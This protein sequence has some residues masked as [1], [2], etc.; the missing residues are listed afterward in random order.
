VIAPPKLVVLPKCRCVPRVGGVV[1]SKL[2][3][4]PI[5]NH[6]PH[7][8]YPST[9]H[10]FQPAS[11]ST[12]TPE[13]I[14]RTDTVGVGKFEQQEYKKPTNFADVKP[15]NWNFVLTV[16]ESGAANKLQPT[17]LKLIPIMD[18]DGTNLKLITAKCQAPFGMQ[19]DD[20]N[21]PQPMIANKLKIDLNVGLSSV[22][23]G[24]RIDDAACMFVAANS[25]TLFGKA[26]SFDTIRHMYTPIV[27]EI[28]QE[29]QR[30]RLRI[31]AT[32]SGVGATKFWITDTD[33]KRTATD[34]V[35]AIDK[36]AEV[37]AIFEACMWVNKSINKWGI[38]FKAAGINVFP[39]PPAPAKRV[40]DD[41]FDGVQ[42]EDMAGA[43][44]PT[45]RPRGC[46]ASD[47]D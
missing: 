21:K 38:T 33:G 37:V 20:F 15:E 36:G 35:P 1:T 45:K 7:S 32:A 31:K 23:A 3:S 39:K 34:D 42:E 43:V 4:H 13:K 24:R 12:S 9:P 40:R 14:T 25:E 6:P 27:T 26:A 22:E 18:A 16:K 28:K 10:T 41:D 11:M 46:E 29:G 5:V 2:F 47:F 44:G 8:S 30:N 19:V 17:I